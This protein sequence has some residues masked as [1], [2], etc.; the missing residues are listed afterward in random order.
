MFV[1]RLVSLVKGG[2]LALLA[3]LTFAQNRLWTDEVRLWQNAVQFAPVKPRPYINLGRALEAVGNDRGAFVAYQRA[4]DLSDVHRQDS[5]MWAFAHAAAQTNLA[6]LYAKHGQPAVSLYLLDGVLR[7][8]PFF[9]TALYNKSAVL[10]RMGQCEQ[11][12]VQWSLATSIDPTLPGRP[13]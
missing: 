4:V 3:V 2:L 10:A 8:Q 6:H 9:T 11:A 13:C 12:I 7:E 5:L 1:V